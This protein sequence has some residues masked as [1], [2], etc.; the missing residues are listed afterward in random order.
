MGVEV[1]TITTDEH[2]A[3][4]DAMMR[5][6]LM[7]PRPGQAEA[8]RPHQDLSRAWAAFDGSSIVGT[9][10]SFASEIT[11]PGGAI[12][13]SA[14]LTNVTMRPTHRRQG[15][16]RRMIEPDLTAARER[17]EPVGM[18]IA[19]E[20][21]IYSRFGYGPSTDHA[22]YTVDARTARFTVDPPGRMEIVDG[23]EL[24]REAPP[25]Y[26]RFRRSTPG[27]IE[28]NEHWWDVNLQIVAVPGDKPWKGFNA[29]YRNER[30]EPE[31]Y[32]RYHTDGEWDARRPNV[33]LTVDELLSVTPAAYVRLWRYCCEVDWVAHVEAG[34]RR[35]DE[36]L[37]WFV[38]D[39]RH[40]VQKWRADFQWL[41][42]LDPA[43]ALG[44]RRYLTPGRV[45]LEV[46]DPL[47]L[48][49][50]RFAV[51]GGPDGASVSATDSSAELTVPVDALGAAYLGGTTL[52]TLARAGRIDVHDDG[53]LA[54][55]D[56]MF[57]G[58]VTPWCTTWF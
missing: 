49:G 56:A 20:Y 37:P 27:A 10:R 7:E 51:D 50:G 55:A 41:R 29:L 26:E 9:L 14:A 30:G 39:A 58:E 36:L 6:F 23:P 25:L 45:V 46:V 16:M 13:P 42:V 57:R 35:V 33:T 4:T 15:I 8:S 17:G 19:A 24:R 3:W 11:V 53:A 1:R 47:G 22:T 21:P 48:A 38:D 44:A 28:R 31:G 32:V 52:R 34:D 54:V 12:V 43:A 2:E 40:V 5:G 18:L